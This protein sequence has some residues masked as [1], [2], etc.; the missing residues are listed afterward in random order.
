LR[1]QAEQEIIGVAGLCF[2]SVVAISS[3][4]DRVFSVL[5]DVHELGECARVVRV[6]RFEGHALSASSAI[7][8][9]ASERSWTCLGLHISASG[10]YGSNRQVIVPVSVQPLGTGPGPV[11]S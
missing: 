10:A 8:G 2:R 1:S 4:R 11:R 6:L 3:E 5:V 9:T 7:D